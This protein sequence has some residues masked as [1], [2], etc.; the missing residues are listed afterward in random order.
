MMVEEPFSVEP[1]QLVFGFSSLL[2]SI[3]ADQIDAWY[4]RHIR[5]TH[6]VFPDVDG[7]NVS[8]TWALETKEIKAWS[9][10]SN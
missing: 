10:A 9:N 1:Y 7:T 2:A 6:T 5:E 3:Y 8:E 4:P